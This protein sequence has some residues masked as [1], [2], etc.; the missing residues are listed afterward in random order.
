MKR[1]AIFMGIVLLSTNIYSQVEVISTDSI[2]VLSPDLENPENNGGLGSTS[3]ANDT[4]STDTVGR[5]IVFWIH[6][7]AGNQSSWGHVY[8]ATRFQGSNPIPNYPER[9]LYGI[10][11]DYTAEEQ[12]DFFNATINYGQTLKV[13]LQNS[14][15]PGIDSSK[16]F[17][18]A[19]SQGGLMGRS[20]RYMSQSNHPNVNVHNLF[21]GLATFGS[22]H[23][24]AAIIN[25][26]D[27]SF[28][29]NWITEGCKALTKS[30]ISL[31]IE[32]K[33]VLE[34]VLPPSVVS[35][36]ASVACT[37]LEKTV[38]PQL[39]NSIRTPLSKDYAKGHPIIDSLNQFSL[40]DSLFPV[41]TFYGEEKEPVFWRLIHTMTLTPDSVITGETLKDNPFGLDD[42][43]ELP[44]YIN[45]KISTYIQKKNYYIQ[46]SR[47]IALY[48]W[49]I[50]GPYSNLAI[51]PYNSS[52]ELVRTY[53]NA[54]HWLGSANTRWKRYI[55]ARRDTTWIDGYQCDCL[56]DLGGTNGYS[57]S[58]TVVQNPSDCNNANAL[59]CNITPR[60]RHELIDEP[61]DGVVPVSSQKRYFGNLAASVKMEETNHM[62]I[63]NCTRT[64]EELNDLFNGSY[65]DKFKLDQK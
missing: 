58:S 10:N 9:I 40:T 29:Q 57:F 28:V 24:G 32:G 4:I 26:T 56:Y 6:G 19:H 34:N 31:F 15:F 13:I 50:P 48:A 21:T 37:G 61:S 65:G 53:D 27:N 43:D 20:L 60:K 52:I 17:A 42:D 62:Q 38:L 12:F 39:V 35:R 36:F 55:G 41:V 5:K 23:Q 63:R 44:R 14:P 49:L 2:R 7:L 59:R 16:R 33:W 1:M 30:E 46:R 54:A 51:I 22:P 18:I 25:N 45:N 47:R 8:H 64:K 11:K 3:G